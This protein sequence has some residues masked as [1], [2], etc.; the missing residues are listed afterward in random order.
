[1]SGDWADWKRE[2]VALGFADYKERRQWNL[3][4]AAALLYREGRVMS[5]KDAVLT[6]S[7]LL[8]EIQNLE[9]GDGDAT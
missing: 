6:A 8:A 1:M 5:L 7:S 9:S 3:L 4:Q 2:Q